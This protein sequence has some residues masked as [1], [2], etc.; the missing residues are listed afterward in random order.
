MKAKEILLIMERRLHMQ[1]EGITSPSEDIKRYT[2]EF[3]AKLTE[4]D[5]ED[6]IEIIRDEHIL[7]SV[8]VPTGHVLAVYADKKT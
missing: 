7:K 8:H 5:G 3:V 1:K 4:I 6:E 2:K